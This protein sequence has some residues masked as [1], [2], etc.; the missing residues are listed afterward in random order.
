MATSQDGAARTIVG[1]R[2]LGDLLSHRAGVDARKTFLIFEDD[3]G[4]RSS[5]TYGSFNE[6][7]NKT[8]NGLVQLGVGKGDRVNL[9]MTNRPEFLFFWFALARIGAVMVPTNPLSP[10]DELAYPVGHSEAV[11]TATIPELLDTVLAMRRQCPSVRQ[12][13]LCASSGSPDSKGQSRPTAGPAPG[14]IAFEAFVDD[15]S[16]EPPDIPDIPGIR[17]QSLDD[18]AILYTSGTTSRP[19]GVQVTQANYVFLGEQASKNVGLRPDDR[20]LV[21]LPLF[22]ANA[23]YY[24]VMTALT[25]GASVAVMAR[26]SASRLMQQAAEHRCTVHSS[27]ATPLRMVLAKQ[28]QPTDGKSGLRL[29][30]LAQSLTTEQYE[31]WDRRYGVPMLQIYGMTE[32]MGQPLV[33]PLDYRRDHLSI[34]LPALGYECRVV[35]DAGNDV[36]QGEAGQ[37]LVRG[38]PGV[39]VMN[40]YFKD[41]TQT[42]AS[43]RGGWL[44]TG[45]VVTVGEDGYYRF[46]D[47]AGDLIRRSGE[48]MSTSEVEAVIKSHPAVADAA[49]VGVPDSMYDEAVMAFVVLSEQTTADEEEI[50]EFC[51]ARLSKFKVPSTVEFMDEFPRTSTGKIRKVDLR[52]AALAALKDG[53]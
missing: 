38:I 18:A 5:W 11:L 48:N 41:P 4:K 45:D 14:M 32:T 30:I 40:G 33:N 8:A 19:K 3:S 44:W 17:V 34:G 2:T 51:R 20:W 35:D 47:R 28:P 27:L 52:K 10:P 49:V 31:E 9:H 36:P 43:L 29:V 21:T 39:T 13:I 7:V 42:A 25:V 22:H 26:F 46:L 12:V 16:P 23:Q 50:L 24:S 6:T 37:L 1:R 15:Q 53:D